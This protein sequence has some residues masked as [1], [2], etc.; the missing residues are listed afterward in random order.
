MLRNC[1]DAVRCPRKMKTETAIKTN[2]FPQFFPSKKRP[3]SQHGFWASPTSQTRRRWV[4]SAPAP[5]SSYQALSMFHGK[6]WG[7]LKKKQPGKPATLRTI[8]TADNCKSTALERSQRV[9]GG[10]SLSLESGTHLHHAC[11]S[12]KKDFN[13]E[14]SY[15][16][17]V[18]HA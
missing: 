16:L 9:W 3:K 8:S 12:H 15:D 13:S 5:N 10:S 2:I 14:T 7:P 17:W 1:G 11:F 4:G 6:S 18:S